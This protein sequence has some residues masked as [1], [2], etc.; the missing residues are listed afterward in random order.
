MI[1]NSIDR[2][3]EREKRSYVILHHAGDLSLRALEYCSDSNLVDVPS[4]SYASQI[5]G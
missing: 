1:D 3:I 4:C 5:G 2:L